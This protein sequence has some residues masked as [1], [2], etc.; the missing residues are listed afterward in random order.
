MH[1]LWTTPELLPSVLQHDIQRPNPHSLFA[2]SRSPA[3]VDRHHI[4]VVK[5]GVRALVYYNW[6]ACSILV[7]RK[8]ECVVGNA[9]A[10]IRLPLQ[11]PQDVP[12]LARTASSTLV[13][14]AL[15]EL[16]FLR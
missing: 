13:L 6:P 2:Q 1:C 16:N 12:P 14:P 9:H 15:E 11:T 3:G 4:S 8:H 5:E 7:P 10:W